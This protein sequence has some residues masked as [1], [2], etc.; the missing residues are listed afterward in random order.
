MFVPPPI[1]RKNFAA[2]ST[3]IYEKPTITGFRLAGRR[4][5][6]TT[7]VLDDYRYSIAWG[8]G[9]LGEVVAL[10]KLP[11]KVWFKVAETHF[12]SFRLFEVRGPIARVAPD[13]SRI[14]NL[15]AT[16]I[17]SPPF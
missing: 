11:E 3:K 4:D 14:A 13:E 9:R 10:Q 8:V 17:R 12:N 7:G 5:N 16:S 1:V 6:P 2:I 15:G